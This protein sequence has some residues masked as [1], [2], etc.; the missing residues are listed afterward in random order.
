MVRYKI[1]QQVGQPT[2][3]AE[4][5]RTGH[6][7]QVMARCNG[8]S[9]AWSLREARRPVPSVPSLQTPTG[10]SV[11]RSFQVLVPSVPT[12]PSRFRRVFGE[13]S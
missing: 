12:V 7:L 2:G 9:G 3:A 10:N 1:L 5:P 6:Q 8:S 4:C 13:S 11:N